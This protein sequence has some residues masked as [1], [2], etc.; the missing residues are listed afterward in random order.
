MARLE[1]QRVLVTQADRYMGPPVVELF[2]AEGAEV[3]ADEGDLAGPKQ[4][5]RLVESAGRIDVLVANFSGPRDAMPVTSMMVDATEFTDRAFQEY[6]D[7]LVWPLL[8]IV[9]ATLPQMVERRAGKVVAATSSTPIRAIPGLS[10]YS[11]ARGAQNAFIQVVGAE[12]RPAQ[13][14]GQRPG[15]RAHRKQHVLHRG[16]ARRRVGAR[17]LRGPD[18]CRPSRAGRRGSR[19]RPRVGDRGQHLH[20]RPGHPHLR[21]VDD[22]ARHPG[23]GCGVGAGNQARTRRGRAMIAATR[24]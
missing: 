2:R 18:P 3:I 21:R 7:A 16:D 4:A 13:R 6:L 9:R 24:A 23:P 8:R 1:G 11:A 17:V 19:T 12:G 5:E 10:V 14:A 22:L 15:Y 20:G